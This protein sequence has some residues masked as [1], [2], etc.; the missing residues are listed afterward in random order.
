MIWLPLVQSLSSAFE[1]RLPAAAVEGRGGPSVA[2]AAEGDPLDANPALAAVAGSRG[3]AGGGLTHPLG[4]EDL[5]L[6]GLWA[7]TRTRAGWAAAVRW[8]T[9]SAGEIYREDALGADLAWKGVRLAVGIG[10]R[11]GHV[12]LE[13]EDL[14]SPLGAS[15]GIRLGMFEGLALAASV[16][17]AS[18]WRTEGLSQP[19]VLGLGAAVAG[20]DSTWAGDAG[21][22]RREG[23][24][25]SG[26]LGQ[27][28]R[29]EP[30]RLRAG[31]RS[32]PWTISVGLGGGLGGARL[33]WALEGEPR[34]G[35]QQHLS[36]AWTF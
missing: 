10:V 34:L 5:E 28:L 12:S 13:G 25:W 16:E 15:A 22:E 9:L 32:W 6:G 36:A 33:D 18:L 7:R 26:R 23:F 17:D 21:L 30:I 19:W 4:M 1:A 29:L 11:A 3:E 8:K 14:G 24:G 35:W 31:I 2:W 20:F 27:E